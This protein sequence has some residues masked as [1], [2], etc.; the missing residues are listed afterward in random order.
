MIEPKLPVSTGPRAAGPV[1]GGSDDVL[2]R[3]E[4][5][6]VRFGGVKALDGVSLD[7]RRGE[8]HAI[9][10][11]NGAGKTTLLNA[12]SGIQALSSGTVALN[13]RDLGGLSVSSRRKLGISRTFQHPSLVGDLDVLRNVTIGSFESHDGTI[14]TELAGTVRQRRRR[15]RAHARAVAALETLE[16]PR[17]RWRPSPATSRWASRSTSTSPARWAPSRRCCCSTSRRPASG[18]RRW[19]RSPRRSRRSATRACRSS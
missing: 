13:G 16:F 6:T 11:P 10:G 19:P 14:W 18:R 1:R 2:L 15:Q 9:I 8:V 7:V 17:A 5:L 12:I 3:I 4:D